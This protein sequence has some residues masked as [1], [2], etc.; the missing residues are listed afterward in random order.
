M[1]TKDKELWIQMFSK[2]KEREQVI[3]EKYEALLGP[4]HTP[5]LQPLNF[6]EA[7]V[8]FR[9]QEE[10]RELTDQLSDM[11]TAFQEGQNPL[12]WRLAYDQR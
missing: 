3:S 7:L 5:R 12:V 6:Q 2:V 1:E 8:K 10:H 9:L 4:H 11:L